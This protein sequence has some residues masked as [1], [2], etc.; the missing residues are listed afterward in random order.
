MAGDCLPLPLRL[1]PAKPADPAAERVVLVLRRTE[2]PAITCV[3][4]AGETLCCWWEES[5]AITGIESFIRPWFMV[6]DEFLV[7]EPAVS[8]GA[9]GKSFRVESCENAAAEIRI[10]RN[11]DK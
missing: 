10:N 4:S 11:P 6:S 5:F 9:A 1:L 7:L 3:E 2:S 8:A